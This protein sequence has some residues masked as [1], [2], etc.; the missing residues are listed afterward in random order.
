MSS[1]LSDSYSFIQANPEPIDF[2]YQFIDAGNST[3]D[4][5]RMPPKKGNNFDSRLEKLQAA[6]R[7]LNM[8]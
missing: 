2:C 6:R 8:R 4:T 1:C 3:V 5:K 7:E